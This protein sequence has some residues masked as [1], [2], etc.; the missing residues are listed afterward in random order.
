MGI[1]NE[2]AVF[3]C[4]AR[5]DGVSFRKTLTLGRQNLYVDDK[6]LKNLAREFNIGKPAL[7]E[8]KSLYS[9][10]FLRQFLIAE[11]I[12][13]L[14]YSDYEGADINH[15]MNL[16]I[17]EHLEEKYDV[18]IDGGTLEHVFNFPVAISNC[19]RM[20][21]SGGRLFIFTPTNNQMGHGYYQFGPELFFRTFC[22]SNGFKIERMIAVEF[23]YMSTEFGS[24]KQQYEVKDPDQVRAR[25][26]L[27]NS[28]PVGL[29]IQAKKT[30]HKS[31][32]F[33]QY[34]QQSDY[35]MIWNG[36]PQEK[37][38]VAGRSSEYVSLLRRLGRR[39][40]QSIRR[41]LALKYHKYFT[42]SFRNRA[43]YVPLTNRK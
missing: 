34:P 14:D 7:L 1:I 26:T 17:P 13:S 12:T 6:T 31:R 9:E 38:A 22:A 32:L 35:Q 40:P 41:I 30:S 37:S 33:E 11:E 2:T 23:K 36:S 39:L 18:I 28:Y 42:H 19:M 24:F 4:Q 43:S 25:V 29:M 20:V 15:D 27:G 10:E 3:M 8:Y 5:S 16:P 21:K